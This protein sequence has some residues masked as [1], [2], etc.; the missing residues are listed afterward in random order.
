MIASV[1]AIGWLVTDGRFALDEATIEVSGLRYTDPSLVRETIGVPVDSTPNLFRLRTEQMH[2]ALVALP[3]V[4]GAEVE[5]VLPNRLIVS[6]S[7]RTPVLAVMRGSSAY[8]VDGDGVLLDMIDRGQT[9]I[10]DLPSIVDRRTSLGVE[11]EVG[12]RLDAT[13]SS[14]MLQLGAITPSLVDSDAASL[15][16]SVDDRD[17]YVIEAAPSGWRAVFG[18]YTPTLRPPEIISQQVQCLR[19]LLAEG[20][21]AIDTV[22]LVPLDDRCGT[23][24]PRE[25]PEATPRMTPSPSPST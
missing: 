9:S 18:H 1:V 16:V 22:Y 8:L 2:R 23:Y 17:G 21:S 25:T 12:Q 14:A 20:E 11:F 3:A 15:T 6:I 10:A 7:E 19:S 5:A 4:A 13:E 24:L